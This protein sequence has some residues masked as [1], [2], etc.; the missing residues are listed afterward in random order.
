MGCALW[1]QL[2]ITLSA[3][4]MLTIRNDALQMLIRRAVISAESF[5]ICSLPPHP[6]SPIKKINCAMLLMELC[7]LID[8][9]LPNDQKMFYLLFISNKGALVLMLT[10]MKF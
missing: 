10:P 1:L 4:M 7:S 6:A 2:F 5:L 8:P 3:E 9:H